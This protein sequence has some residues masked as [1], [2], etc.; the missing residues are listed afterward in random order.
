TYALASM[1]DEG[2]I[3]S[4]DIRPLLGAMPDNVVTIWQHSVTEMLNNVIDHSAGHA[5]SIRLTK[6][7]ATTCVVI[8]D[9]GEGIFQK[10]QGALGL[11]D[12]RHAVIELTKGKLTTDPARHSGE[13]IFFTSRMVDE[14][15]LLSGHVYL[16]HLQGEDGDWILQQKDLVPGTMVV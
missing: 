5:V 6:T 12:E 8:D 15:A 2:V 13:G 3:W 14:F 1:P 10:I 9:D 7:A 4:R 16:S 11:E